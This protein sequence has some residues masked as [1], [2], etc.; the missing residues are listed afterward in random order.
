[1]T[2]APLL[3][4]LVLA[5]C[6]DTAPPGFSSGSA[7][8]SVSGTT[9]GSSTSGDS[10]ST[11]SADVSTGS[12]TGESTGIIRDVGAETDFGTGQPL[13]CQGKVDLLF[14][15]A[16]SGNM[17]YVQDQFLASLPGFVQTIE[18]KLEGFD[19]HIMTANPDGDWPGYACQSSPNGCQKF[20]PT[21]GPGSENW[22]CE[23]S[24]Q[25]WRPCDSELG[26]GN[27]F[28]AGWYAT[29][30]RCELFGDNRYII[31]GE[32]DLAGNLECIAK[33]GTAGGAKIGDALMAA[34]SPKLNA[35]TGCNAGFLRDDAL[36]VVV[37]IHNTE[38]WS[39]SSPKTQ[40]DKV[41]AA[42]KDPGAVVMLAITAPLPPGEGE[43]LDPDC[44]YDDGGE[45]D[46]LPLLEQ[47]PYHLR[48]N[49]CTDSYVPFFEDAVA[50]IDEACGKF[51]PK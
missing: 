47:F 3:A 12:S 51:V 34:V 7:V 30:E 18:D 6:G 50:M 19:V 25:E 10:S 42:K 40:Y 37:I 36:L 46:Y 17:K 22:D 23:K 31:S 32:P 14:L 20:Y 2:R 13:G 21:C 43:P 45:I 16:R 41:I 35:P 24:V 9:S 48:G 26:A 15:I 8:T 28:N 4:A 33:V 38:D 44:I 11:S 1:M 49:V 39:L 5:A 27:T 29:N